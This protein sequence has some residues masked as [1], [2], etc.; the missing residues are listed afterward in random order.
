MSSMSGLAW[1]QPQEEMLRAGSP[2]T[3]ST[4]DRS[5]AVDVI[6]VAQLAGVDQPLD[7]LHRVAEQVRVVDHQHPPELRSQGDQR[8]RLLHGGGEGLLDH[9]VQ[10]RFEAAL[11]DRVVGRDR[12]RDGDGLEAG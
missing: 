8:L 1:E 5:G 2:T 6:E 11:G 4:I 9:H 3:W 10:P 12:G 7:Q